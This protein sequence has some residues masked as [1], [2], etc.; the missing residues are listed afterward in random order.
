VA[1]LVAVVRGRLGAIG[2]PIAGPLLQGGF[3]DRCGRGE[4]IAPSARP[5]ARDRVCRA[6]HAAV[7]RTCCEPSGAYGANM[8]PG[9]TQR[10]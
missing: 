8:E 6:L 10:L 9:L 3:R 2:S 7:P 1:D 4:S 5:A